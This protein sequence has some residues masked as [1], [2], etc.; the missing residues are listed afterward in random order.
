MQRLCCGKTR[1]RRLYEPLFLLG[2]LSGTALL[3]AIRS[4]LEGIY[5]EAPATN[6][7]YHNVWSEA[8][9]PAYMAVANGTAKNMRDIYVARLQPERQNVRDLKV[10]EAGPIKFQALIAAALS[11]KPECKGDK[12]VSTK[13]IEKCCFGA[14]TGQA[15]SVRYI[16]AQFTKAFQDNAD[17]FAALVAAC[18]HLG[19]F[20]GAPMAAP[21]TRINFHTDPIA[22]IN[23]MLTVLP[24]RILW[25]SLIYAITGMCDT[26]PIYARM[27]KLYFGL[28]V[29]EPTSVVHERAATV[30]FKA[31]P[32]LQNTVALDSSRCRKRVRP[33]EE[34]LLQH[35]LGSV[36]QQKRRLTETGV[37]S[38]FPGETDPA[39]AKRR[40]AP[41]YRA[42]LDAAPRHPRPDVALLRSLGLNS[43][44]GRLIYQH[45]VEQ[46]RE[47]CVVPRTG[48]LQQHTGPHPHALAKVCL[49]C[50]SL[51]SGTRHSPSN[52]ATDGTIMLRDGREMCAACRGTNCLTFSAEKF[53]VTS[54]NKHTDSKSIVSQVCSGCGFLSVIKTVIGIHPFCATCAKEQRTTVKLRC[55]VCEKMLSKRS[56]YMHVLQHNEK[57]HA[58]EAAV[59]AGCQ[60]FGLPHTP[61][62]WC[63]PVLKKLQAA[64]RR[65]LGLILR[66]NTRRRGITAALK[67]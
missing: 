40:L 62:P 16:R 37:L 66:K 42:V 35:A 47:F 46:R 54:L 11:Q 58:T 22:Q 39:A 28:Y 65:Q 57:G 17:S 15:E 31:I 38:L 63:L 5:A 19:S 13:L 23:R 53:I 14:V 48:H 43:D 6:S 33:R 36:A 41:I 49:S 34:L 10:A 44:H 30:T 51:R 2:S 29:P 67:M 25:V 55:C 3:E 20:P 64:R 61:E 4:R 32:A 56:Y 1:N 9:M 27:R 21:D 12:L 45:A 59:C 50:F 60:N 24:S 8:H 7:Y 26:N 52:K 18:L